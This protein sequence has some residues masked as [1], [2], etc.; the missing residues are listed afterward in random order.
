MQLKTII[1]FIYQTLET[2]SGYVKQFQIQFS[3]E[4]ALKKMQLLSPCVSLQN[5]NSKF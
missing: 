3:I 4:I 2:F 5:L 1:T